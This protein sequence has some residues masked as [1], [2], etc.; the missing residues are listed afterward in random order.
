M[1]CGPSLGL[2]RQLA[3]SCRGAAAA[4]IVFDISSSD[5][6]AKAREWVKE[7]LRQGNPGMIM[8]LAGNKA[9]LAETR[10]VRSCKRA[11]HTCSRSGLWQGVYGGQR[12]CLLDMR[13]CTSTP[14]LYRPL[15]VCCRCRR[16]TR[17]HMQMKMGWCTGRRPPRPMPTCPSSLTTLRSGALAV[18]A[19]VGCAYGQP[20]SAAVLAEMSGVPD[21]SKVAG[22]DTLQ[23]PTW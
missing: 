11:G 12:T 5:S 10:E 7:L 8:S 17:R 15:A 16:R 2:Q 18:A 3:T 23:W 14:V 22:T 13:Q 21:A 1:A 19:A 9:D 4:V 6:F 20:S